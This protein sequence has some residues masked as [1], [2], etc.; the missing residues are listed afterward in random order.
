MLLTLTVLTVVMLVVINLSFRHGFDDYLLERELPVAAQSV[1]RLARHFEQTGSW[2]RLHNNPRLWRQLL[3]SEALPFQGAGHRPGRRPPPGFH[4]PP[5]YRRPPPAGQLA[6]AD[7]TMLALERRLTLVD[8]QRQHVFGKPEH[9]QVQRWLPVQSSGQTVGWLGVIPQA[10]ATDRLA[11]RFVEQQQ[12]QLALIAVLG[13]FLG[14]LVSALLA[15][16]FLRPVSRVT[17]AA[18]VLANGDLSVRVPVE[19]KDELAQLSADFN[20]MAE[21]LQHDDVMRKQWVSDISHELRT[22]LAVLRGEIEALQDGI[23]PPTSQRLASLQSEVCGLTRLVEDL[24]QLSKSDMGVME[25]QLHD[26]DMADVCQALYDRFHPRMAARELHL[27]MQIENQHRYHLRGDH[28][29]LNQLLTNLLE[30]SLRYTDAGGEVVLRLSRTAEPT[31]ESLI[32]NIMDS[33]PGVP[34]DA[35]P[36]IFERLYRV[37]RSRSRALGGSGLGLSICRALVAAHGGQIKAE[38]RA[39]GGLNITICLPCYQPASTNRC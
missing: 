4:P 8:A 38:N 20:R 36:R 9:D 26:V 27:T 37:D 7:H 22:P 1:D 33:A 2:Q 19:G 31:P 16:W 3:R 13:V 29:R 15:R 28:Q 39:T 32:I 35:L 30:N 5:E 10:L 11:Q 17:R 23:R 6:P 25:L 34:D 21:K 12:K 18:G 24:H 14:L